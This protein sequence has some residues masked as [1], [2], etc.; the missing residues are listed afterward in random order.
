MEKFVQS[1]QRPKP[2]PL[3]RP[4]FLGELIDQRPLSPTLKRYRPEAVDN[5]VTQW[6]ESSYRERHCQSDSLLGHSDGDLIS[7][8]LTKSASNMAYRQ[9][10][11]GFAVPP[12]SASSRY[13]ASSTTGVRNPLYRQT[14]LQ[15]NDIFVR[16]PGSL[17]PGRVSDHVHAVQA[18]RDSPGLSSD[19]LDQHI[20]RLDNLAAGCTESQVG[21]FLN[22]TIFPNPGSDLVYG[23]ATGLVSSAGAPMCQH[24]VP[25][26]PTRL[27]RVTQPRPDLLYG[28]SGE[29]IT[30]PFTQPQLMAQTMLHP[31]HQD[32]PIAT[33]QGL[34]F[35]FFAIEFKAAGGTRGDLWVAANQCA[36]ASSACVNA[37]ERLNLLLQEHESV[38]L[39][40]N[41]TYSVAVD[42]NTAQLYISW[43]ED[44]LNYFLQRVDTF[45][46][47][48]Q[49]DFKDFRKQVRNI[50]DW[51]KDK[52]LK[53]ICNA[54][55]IILEE[56][57]KKAAEREKALQPPSKTSRGRGHGA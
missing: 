22:D 10:A 33:L 45:L 3:K 13:S 26:N 7:G 49:D 25:T 31:R 20:H 17:L 15:F 53:Q 19:Q 43:K 44:E 56:N 36:G 51:G 54:L 24:L 16:H 29:S 18:E 2:L 40:D 50:L 47:S 1:I 38:E 30:G 4:L 23:P 55:D 11:D 42:N 52:R 28:Y 34:R 8:R 21:A 5:F 27:Y 57:S 41:V 9:D 39:V 48:R 37:V 12:I 46:L 32:Y 6:V 14:S 35:P